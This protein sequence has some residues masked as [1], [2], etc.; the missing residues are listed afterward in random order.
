VRP[1]RSSAKA[2]GTRGTSLGAARDDTASEPADHSGG[3]ELD[4]FYLD[5]DVAD[6]DDVVNALGDLEA[7][8]AESGAPTDQLSLAATLLDRWNDADS[9]RPA[10]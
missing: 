7:Q 5:L 4:F 1:P 3:R 10:V 2:R 9:S 8:M 6:V